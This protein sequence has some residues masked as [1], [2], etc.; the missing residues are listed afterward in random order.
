M[1]VPRSRSAVIAQLIESFETPK[2]SQHLIVV[3]SVAA[4]DDVPNAVIH[5]RGSPR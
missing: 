3:L 4:L 5:M 1:K 2:F